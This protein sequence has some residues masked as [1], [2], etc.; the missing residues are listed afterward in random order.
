MFSRGLV[1][2][3]CDVIK[4]E[5][6]LHPGVRFVRLGQGLIQHWAI[7]HRITATEIFSVSQHS[8][9]P[10]NYFDKMSQLKL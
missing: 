10:I 7:T 9:L 2:C 4:V 1:V 3:V 8:V 6:L 5:N